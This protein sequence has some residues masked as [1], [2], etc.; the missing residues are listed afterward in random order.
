[1]KNHFNIMYFDRYS[2]SEKKETVYASGFLNWCYNYKSGN[3]FTNLIFSRKTFTKIY[4]LLNSLSVSRRKIK[5]FMKNYNN[6]ADGSNLGID[7]YLSFNDFF[8]RKFL[9]DQRRILNDKNYCIAPADGR[10]LAFE[11][12]DLTTEFQIKR[13]IFNLETLVKDNK[14]LI[15]YKRG[16]V[17]ICRLHLSDYHRFHFPVAGIVGRTY[18]IKG[19]YHA[20][21]PYAINNFMP[22]L[23]ENYRVL[24]KI[25]SEEFGRILMVEIG[26]MTV[27]S[28]KQIFLENSHVIKGMEK[29]YF[30]LGGSTIVLIFENNRIHF[31]Y[32]LV[33]NTEKSMETYIK[34]G[35]SVG[36]SRI[37]ED[38]Q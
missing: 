24:T 8:I 27:G 33:E 32:D 6:E 14:L 26:A 15:D 11:N 5:P 23:S 30:E 37:T 2:N 4:G 13:H 17:L 1:M 28:I 20:G 10:Y 36:K 34:M 22:G 35:D 9:P 12:I 29:G 18:A 31:D 16:S 3:L 19:K 21:G 25:D 7:E 38:H